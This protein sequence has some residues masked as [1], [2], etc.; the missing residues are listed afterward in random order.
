LEE[1]QLL[2]GNGGFF[3]KW[4]KLALTKVISFFLPDRRAVFHHVALCLE[5]QQLEA[6][7]HLA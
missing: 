4:I 6:L 7:T 1:K 2:Q 3:S 5:V